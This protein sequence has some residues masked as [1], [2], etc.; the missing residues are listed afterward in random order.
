MQ[1]GDYK[2]RHMQVSTAIELFGKQWEHFSAF[3]LSEALV[4]SKGCVNI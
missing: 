2:S 4:H 3:H 1:G